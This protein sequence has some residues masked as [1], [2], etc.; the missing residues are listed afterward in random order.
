M[1]GAGR[2]RQHHLRR[3]PRVGGRLGRRGQ[4]AGHH[5]HAHRRREGRQ[6][7]RH[8]S[9]LDRR[10]D[11]AAA[12]VREGQQQARRPLRRREAAP[13]DHRQGPGGACRQADRRHQGAAQA[14]RDDARRRLPDAPAGVL[15][16]PHRREHAEERH[17]REDRRRRPGHRQRAARLPVPDPQDRQ[18]GDVEPPDELPRPGLHRQVRH[19]ERRRLGPADAVDHRRGRLRLADVRRQEDRRHEGHR[20]VLVRQVPVPGAGAPQRRSHAGARLGQPA[21]AGA[22]RL[23]VPARPAPRAARTRYRL[24]HAEPRLGRRQHL[25]RRLAVQRCAWTATTSS[26][27]ARRK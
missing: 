17:R 20:P 22:P 10:H 6:Q 24:R 5:A 14:P 21:Q 15:P 26:S 11:D 13:G 19:L 3:R 9:R 16:G 23:A 27:S 4:A 18:R 2:H 25:R 1:A 12:Q 8:D 7:G